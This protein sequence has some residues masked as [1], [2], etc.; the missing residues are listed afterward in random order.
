MVGIQLPTMT[1][2]TSTLPHH[3]TDTSDSHHLPTHA[4]DTSESHAEDVETPAS[5]QSNNVSSERPK[6]RW[7]RFDNY[8]TAQ[9]YMWVRYM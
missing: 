9:G 5:R 1:K 6:I 2:T 8:H 7:Y 3:A 4:T